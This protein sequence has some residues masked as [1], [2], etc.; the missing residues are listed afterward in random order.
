[1]DGVSKV[2]HVGAKFHIGIAVLAPCQGVPNTGGKDT[3]RS[4]PTDVVLRVLETTEP[5]QM[6]DRRFSRFF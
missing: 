2:R 4:P 1:M 6:L 3:T 5:T